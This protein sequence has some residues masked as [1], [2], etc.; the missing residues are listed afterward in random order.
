MSVTTVPTS[1]VLKPGRNGNI[2]PP[3]SGFQKGR[4]GH[5]GGRIPTGTAS[6]RRRMRDAFKEDVDRNLCTLAIQIARGEQVE[7]LVKEICDVARSGQEGTDKVIAALGR[8][9]NQ[10]QATQLQAIEF[11]KRVGFGQ[12]PKPIDD[13]AA[14][15]LVATM[16]EAARVRAAERAKAIEAQTAPQT[17]THQPP[18]E[19][20]P[21]R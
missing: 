12:D 3:G 2:L 21:V 20:D 14:A 1:V 8:T 6:L 7:E 15:E 16:L 5:P 10:M 4:S 19:P 11:C 18:R 17:E 13:S 9:L